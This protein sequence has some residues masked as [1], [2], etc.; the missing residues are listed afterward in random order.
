MTTRKFLFSLLGASLM[1]GT[2]ALGGFHLFSNDGSEGKSTLEQKQNV[3]LSKYYKEPE[4][5]DGYVVPDGLNF[6]SAAEKVTPAV[7]HIK[8]YYNGN[9]SNYG[10]N[11]MED[12]LRDFFGD[13]GGGNRGGGMGGDMQRMASG[14]GVIITADGYIATNN[15]VIEDA[16][17]VEV[18]LDDKRKF[19]AKVIG[20]DPTTDL[21][22]LKV[23][24]NN[25]DFVPY[26]NSD[27]VKI[28]QWVLAVGNPFDLT[29]TVTAGIVSAKGR[30]I[31]ILRGRSN[32][33]IESFI[34]T[35]AAVNPGNSGGALVD[36]NGKL[37]GINTA[38]A[39]NT[40]SYAGYSFAVPVDLA[41]KVMEDLAEYGEVRRALMGVNIQDVTA[42]LAENKGFDKIKGVY[43][44]GVSPNGGAEAAGIQLGDV[45]LAVD[46]IEVNSVAE[47]QELVAR[48]RPDEEITITYHRDG[49][50]QTTA[51][52]LQG[53]RDYTRDLAEDGSSRSGTGFEIP[54]LDGEFAEVSEDI[55]YQLGI[56][57]GVEVLSL[58]DGKLKDA[59]L[60]EGFIITKVDKKAIETPADLKRVIEELSGG[61]LIEGYN[62][63]GEKEYVG[64]G[65]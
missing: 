41:K 15:H 64:I 65:F 24:A 44:A 28:G 22:L 52:T 40:G 42:E 26:G 4:K 57:Y 46:G 35:D 39:T 27:N 32:L 14:S 31:N 58:E 25:L 59:G 63:R 43:I 55:K 48:H 60:S 8:T 9:A 30:N 53:A 6:V 37:I 10:R 1:G 3:V 47:L 36:L 2:I 56:D 34:Q 45:I 17:K 7:V 33:S 16:A 23:E 29:S 21:A 61:A 49:K 51:I 54:E 12:M 5:N 11:S 19:E 18:V 50:E 62:K 13:Q 20:T 38:I